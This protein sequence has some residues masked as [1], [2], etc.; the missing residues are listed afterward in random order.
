MAIVLSFIITV[1]NKERYISR[2]VDSIKNQ[3][4]NVSCEYIFV[5][6]G[7]VDESLSVLNEKCAGLDGCVIV[8]QENI[9]VVR[10]TIKAIRMARGEYIKFV[11]GDDYIMD[12]LVA[13]Q[14]NFLQRNPSVSYV[15]CS[16]GIL[17]ND[18]VCP[19]F[20]LYPF[21]DASPLE[22]DEVDL[23]YGKDA[24][25]SVLSRQGGYTEALTG[26]SGG[27]SR[28]SSI[29]IN[30]AIAIVQEHGIRQVQD[31]LISAVSLLNENSSMAFIKRIGFFEL[32]KSSQEE[33]SKTLS[34]NQSK[35]REEVILI[36]YS[37][38]R[39]LDVN[40]QMLVMTR[41]IKRGVRVLGESQG[42]FN[43]IYPFG[44]LRKSRR[45]LK[46]TDS[47]SVSLLYE[48]MIRKII[49]HRNETM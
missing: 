43:K 44:F 8:D 33:A 15:S 34:R 45:V 4:L 46:S 10:S 18:V 26:M 1:Y 30:K 32:S 21:I 9:G 19:K 41:D 48:N 3:S 35:S 6:D 36:N 29:D 37:L 23:F 39:F 12:G 24:L 47:I 49:L 31:H 2:V 13:A 5:N 27:L 11:D 25:V 22:D 20:K 16:F 14:L 42:W 17:K 7:S 38:K 40:L 28:K